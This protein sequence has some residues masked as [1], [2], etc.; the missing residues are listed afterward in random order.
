MLRFASEPEGSADSLSPRTTK[1]VWVWLDFSMLFLSESA[2]DE[3]VGRRA[4][5]HSQGPY[6]VEMVRSSCLT[7]GRSSAAF[8]RG[9][10]QLFRSGHSGR[11]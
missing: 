3:A 4:I 1:I 10:F 8:F 2:S 5:I 11:G 6:H 7:G 9:L